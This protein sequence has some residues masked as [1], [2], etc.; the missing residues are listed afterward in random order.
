MRK[1]NSKNEAPKLNAVQLRQPI[2]GV[3]FTNHLSIS[4]HITGVITKC[5]Q[6]L[7]ASKK[8]CEVRDLV[9]TIWLYSV[10][11]SCVGKDFM[12]IAGLVGLC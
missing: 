9:R 2:L 5:A 1:L 8:F 10:Q 3:S 7:Y 11:V 6:S 12:R 4:D